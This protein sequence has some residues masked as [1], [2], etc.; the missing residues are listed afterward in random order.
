[1]TSSALTLPVAV[2]LALFA[3]TAEAAPLNTVKAG[4]LVIDPPTLDSHTAVRRH[5]GGHVVAIGIYDNEMTNCH[6]NTVE[7]DDAMPNVA[8]GHGGKAP[9]LGALELGQPMPHYGPRSQARGCGSKIQP[10]Q[11]GNPGKQH[12]Q[13][14]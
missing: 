13:Q 9:D 1:M 11:S 14:A 4:D 5:G 6:D 10:S 12:V 3:V 7:I 2:L 8:D